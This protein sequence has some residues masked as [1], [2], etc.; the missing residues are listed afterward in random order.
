MQSRIT[1]ASVFWF[2]VTFDAAFAPANDWQPLFNGKDLAGWK[3]VGKGDN[4]GV[5]DGE[6]RSTGNPGA[7]WIRTEQ[8]YA[9]FDLRFEYKLEE[10]GNSGVFIRA[11]ERGAPWVEGLEIQLLDDYGPKWKSLKP[12]QFTASIYAVV[13]PAKRATKPAGHWQAM[14]IQCLN[15]HVRVWVNSEQVVDADLDAFQDQTEKVPGLKR[16]SGYIGFQDHG[17][18]AAFRK[19]EIRQLP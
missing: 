16:K 14:R 1:L 13:A 9:N 5:A 2:I 3:P 12:A 8:E 6:L 11:P 19:I 15:R 18:P 17:D 7:H 10:N 4:W